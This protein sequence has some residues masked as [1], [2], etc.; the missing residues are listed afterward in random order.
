MVVLDLVLIALVITVEPIPL[1]AF[2]LVLSARRGIIKGLEFILGWLLSLVVVIGGVVLVTGGKPP[3]PQ[4]SPSTTALAV[5]IAIGVLLILVAVRQKRRIG[6]PRKPPSWMSKLDNLS[7]WAAVGL[8]LFLQPWPLVAAGAATVVELHV[9]SIESYV[10]LV[11]FCLLSTASILA[12]EIHATLSP[13]V[14]RRRLDALRQWIDNHR[15]PVII[16]LS[17]VLGLWLMGHS[18]YL[19]VS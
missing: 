12:L 17:L 19:I 2:I 13:E 11:G 3:R 10:L 7:G 4:T 6:R 18:I 15:D 9:S 14:A 1:T 8:G 5:K 16:I